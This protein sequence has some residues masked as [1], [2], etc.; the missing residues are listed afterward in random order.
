MTDAVGTRHHIEGVIGSDPKHD[1]VILKISGKGTP[2]ALGNSR[3]NE[4]IFVAGYPLGGKYKVTW[5]TIHDVQNSDKRILLKTR[6]LH[7][8]SGGAVVNRKGEVIG[9]ATGYL[10][11]SLGYAISSSVLGELLDRLRQT[12]PVQVQRLDKWQRED[13]IRAYWYTQEGKRM[14]DSGEAIK[15]IKM[16]DEAIN[17]YRHFYGAYFGRGTANLHVGKLEVDRGNA[18]KARDSYNAAIIDFDEAIQLKPDY[19]DAYNGRG[20]VKHSLGK[21]EVDRGNAEKARDSYNAAIIDFDE[22]IQLIPY[23]ADAYNG[24]GAVKHSLGKLEVDRGNV[25]KARDS[26]NAA[27]IDFDE[28]IK[29]DYADAYFHRGATKFRVGELESQKGKVKEAQSLYG[30]ILDDWTESIKLNPDVVKSFKLYPGDAYGYYVK[31]GME[32]ILGQSKDNQG[33][34]EKA[35]RHYEAAYKYYEKATKLNSDDVEDYS[36]Y[37]QAIDLLNPVSADAY[38]LQGIMRA[39]LGKSKADQ[40]NA[41]EAWKHYDAAIKDFGEAIKLNL[42]NAYAYGN[43]GYTKYLLGKSLGSENIEH[44]QN[45]Y[46]EAVA[47]SNNAIGLNSE[48]ANAY[49]IR[50]CA[51]SALKDYNNAIAD[52]NRALELKSDF[53]EVYWERGLVNQKLGLH[54]EADADFRKAKEIDPDIETI[55]NP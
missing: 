29:L 19:A 35:L 28:A 6:L 43:L 26:Y 34:G 37:T 27:I 52:F 36:Y 1:L 4:L 14:D 53:A 8:Y 16:F 10:G 5:G 39:T 20:A 42:N 11:D 33:D 55:V 54:K 13:S 40:G 7:G 41:A 46:D 9:V 23:Y 48:N 30:E 45:L 44:A 47:D 24:R 18:E 21:L 51:K 50:G 22:A 15:A 3:I 2:L 49:F 17:L 38:C 31:G 25:E 12:Q 32:L